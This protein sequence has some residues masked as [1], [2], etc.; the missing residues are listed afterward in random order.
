[1]S[2]KV[3]VRPTTSRTLAQVRNTTEGVKVTAVG[4]GANLLGS[5]SIGELND[6]TL[7]SL[8]NGAVLIYSAVSSEFQATSS[9]DGGIF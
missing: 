6:V 2:V 8:E 5:S 3:T 7:D 1:M 9:I 4:I